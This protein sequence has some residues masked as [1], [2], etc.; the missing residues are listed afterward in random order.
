[1]KKPNIVKLVDE[2]VGILDPR[3]PMRSARQLVRTCFVDGENC[4]LLHHHRGSFWQFR[5]NHYVQADNETVRTAA[6][7]FLE[8]AKQQSKKG[9]APFKPTSGRVSDVLDA[10]AAVC[11]LDSYIDPPAW[12][13]NAYE[14]PP[15][16]E[17]LPVANGLLHLPT[18][19]LF[20]VTPS[21]FGLNASEVAF[22]RNAPE[23]G[24]WHA[25]L[26]DLF[27]TDA[28]SVTTLQDWFGYALGSDTSLQK[29]LL[30]VGPRR[31]GKGTIARVLT[32]L[33]GRASVAAPTLAGLQA[34]FGLAPLI[35]KALAIISDARLGGKSDQAIL[36]ERLLSISGEDAI[37]IDRKY[38]SSW[39]G[40][41]PTRFMVLTNELPRIADSSG[42]LAGRFIVIVLQNSFFGKEDVG[43]AGCL[44]T[45]LPGVLNWA[46]VGYRR[47]R[48]RGHFI[49]PRSSD[50][51]IEELE[52]LG[53]PIKAYIRDR[54]RIGPEC[55]VPVEL[56]YQTTAPG[57]R[58]T[59]A[60]TPAPNKHSAAI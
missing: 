31:S 5:L 10:L 44:L 33:L 27:G 21:H 11:N 41:L 24:H 34:H 37:T 1:M 28:E 56:I 30:L 14:L 9:P 53:S 25:F 49:Q 6:W 50:E 22:D 18:D 48:Q 2:A 32:E 38:Q 19:E 54:C 60:A 59:A 39:T 46:L 52:A 47:I 12:L 13:G 43:L 29:I 16:C 42:A 55:S 51:A 7:Q 17:M 15:A 35:G 58:T 3:N 40:R 26:Q 20:R 4:R 57:V 23:P 8:S 45:E 36:A